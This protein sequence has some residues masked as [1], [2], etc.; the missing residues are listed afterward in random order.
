M[1]SDHDTEFDGLLSKVTEGV[2]SQDDLRRLERLLTGDTG[3]QR[4]YFDWLSTHLLLEKEGAIRSEVETKR[5]NTATPS[6]SG[7]RTGRRS[8]ASL[9]GSLRRGGWLATAAIVL[10]AV[11]GLLFRGTYRTGAVSFATVVDA[12]EVVGS[13]HEL[14]AEGAVLD[15]G[16][17]LRFES[18]AV[19]VRM[20]SEASFTVEGPASLTVTGENRVL[21]SEGR[22]FVRVPPAGVGFTVETPSGSLTDLGTEFGVVVDQRGATQS[23]VYVGEV[24]AEAGESSATLSAGKAIRIDVEGRLGRPTNFSL[25]DNTFTRSLDGTGYVGAIELLQP[26]YLHRFSHTS[27]QRHFSSTAGKEKRNVSL[28]GGVY[29]AAGGPIVQPRSSDG[30][31]RFVGVESTAQVGSVQEALERSEAYSIV[32]WCRVDERGPQGLAAFAGPSGPDIDLGAVLRTTPSGHLE[33]RCYG[34]DGVSTVQRS[35]FSLPIGAWT[36]VVATGGSSSELRLYINGE[37]A[38]PRV[39]M[40]GVIRADCGTLL[41]GSGAGRLLEHDLETGP[42]RGAIDE[43]AVFDRR[44]T[45]QEVRS[46]YR[47]AAA[48][49]PQQM[50]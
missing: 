45:S 26:L 29:A 22:L 44:L 47:V 6:A 28:R 27:K 14:T 9:G 20:P 10:I 36:Q 35:G 17:P 2:A 25:E 8:G 5:L 33:H 50:L 48:S 3:R 34:A 19:S 15:E 32:L 38:S 41:L 40:P 1:R 7:P 46:L 30:C 4:A 43:V 18:G 31:L 49:I 12:V 16:L 13:P 21:L 37:P 24:R 42:L 11:G 23:Y 39:E